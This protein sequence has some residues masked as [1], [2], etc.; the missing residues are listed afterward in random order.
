MVA[1]FANKFRAAMSHIAPDSAP[2]EMHRSMAEPGK[3]KLEELKSKRASES[4]WDFY[5]APKATPD[6]THS[7]VAKHAFSGPLTLLITS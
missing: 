7:C 2:A 6:W 3:A 5:V 4:G 1:G